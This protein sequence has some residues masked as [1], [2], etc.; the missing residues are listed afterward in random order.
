MLLLVVLLAQAVVPL[1][2]NCLG[3]GRQGWWMLLR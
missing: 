3:V 1:P 2:M